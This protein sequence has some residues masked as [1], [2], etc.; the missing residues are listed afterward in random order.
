MEDVNE[1]ENLKMFGM[2]SQ[3]TN[4]FETN[5]NVVIWILTTQAVNTS[6]LKIDLI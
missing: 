1:L 2:D 3:S 6:A 5:P 4:Q